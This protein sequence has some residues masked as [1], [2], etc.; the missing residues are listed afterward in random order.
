MSSSSFEV[1]VASAVLDT[2]LPT[3]PARITATGQVTVSSQGRRGTGERLVYSSETDQ[4]V[5]TGTAANPP[6]FADPAKGTVS[7][8]SL[9]F[10]SRDDSVSIEGDGRKTS[11]ETVA[12]K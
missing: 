12:P 3:A 8:T 5:L 9:I 6:R 1:V 10:N 11:T 2:T 4:Y 7:G